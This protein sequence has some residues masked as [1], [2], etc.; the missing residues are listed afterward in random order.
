MAFSE[1]PDLC[2]V[3]NWTMPAKKDEPKS[4]TVTADIST[5]TVIETLLRVTA[6]NDHRLSDMADNKAQILIT[7]NSIII[8]AI[9]SL[10]LRNLKDNTFL[11][12]PSYIL[13]SVSLLTMI[14]AILATR[15]S[16]PA[17]R[18]SAKDLANK[19]VN[20]LFF[21]NFYKM[22]LDDYAKGMK[23]ILTD[24]EFLYDSLIKDVYTQGIV[25][26]RKYRLLR[27]AYNIFMFGLIV[28]IVTFIVS[29]MR[30]NSL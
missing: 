6:N 4:P 18:F 10:I 27:A 9:I 29:S 21:G 8:S 12:L 23:S 7:V 1:N 11:V 5:E 24:Q 2:T 19:K 28:A 20:L 26:G 30:H 16:I 3:N 13:L 14:L 17:G 22:K 25:L 15:P